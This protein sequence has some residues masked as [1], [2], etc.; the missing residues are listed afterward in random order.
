MV[1]V[2]RARKRMCLLPARIMLRDLDRLG[3]TVELRAGG[4]REQRSRGTEGL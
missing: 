3:V 1:S 4:R 2:G